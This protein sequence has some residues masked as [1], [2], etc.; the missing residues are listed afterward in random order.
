MSRAIELTD[1]HYEIIERVAAR[2]GQTPAALL[3]GLIEELDDPD[4]ERRSYETEDWFEHL[5]ATE[6]QV[7]VASLIA[8]TRGSAADADA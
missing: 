5:G 1:E 4:G 6:E 7:M 3:A 2:R 8:Q